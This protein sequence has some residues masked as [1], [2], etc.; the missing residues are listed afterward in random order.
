MQAPSRN[1]SP[2]V[3]A[4]AFAFAMLYIVWGS[5]YLAIRFAVDTIPP[6]L[7]AGGR[8]LIAG[9]L[10][11]AIMRPRV[12]Q[13]P[14]WAHWR[15]AA[16]AGCFLLVGA[17][18]MV[19]W[20]EQHVSSS[21]A[22]LLV[23]TMPLWMVTLDW[24]FFGGPRQGKLVIVGLVIGLVGMYVLIGPSKLGGEPVNIPGAVALLCACVSW[25]IG[26]LF[27][28]RATLHPS[29]ILVTA[30]EMLAAG[31]V[32]LLLG[33]LTKEWSRFDVTA[34]TGKS[35]LALAYLAVFGSIVALSCYS[36]L[37]QVSTPARVATYAYVN[38]VIAVILGVWLG[39]E[40]FEQR[41]WVAV[42]IIL[43]AVVLI[44]STRQQPRP[45]RPQT[46]T[47]SDD[48]ECAPK[49]PASTPAIAD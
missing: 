24:L 12:A 10:L 41:T 43:V 33:T 21:H 6:F 3:V 31:P 47:D 46:A 36:W 42:A 17:N 32:L 37:L 29:S 15:S 9:G 8:F 23:G 26:S 28:R 48:A 38:P 14:T 7:M 49:L 4:V 2:S 39:N 34:V 45:Q 18:G 40:K 20:A 5:T 1:S 35:W 16:I 27:A 19:C 25:S 30:M 22:A 13:R 44:T 11:Y